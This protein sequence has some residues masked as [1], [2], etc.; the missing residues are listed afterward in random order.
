M[1]LL[2]KWIDALKRIAKVSKDKEAFKQKMLI[3]RKGYYSSRESFAYEGLIFLKKGVDSYP[4]DYYL[5][6]YAC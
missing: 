5:G 4:V 6:V 1:N 2:N 3:G